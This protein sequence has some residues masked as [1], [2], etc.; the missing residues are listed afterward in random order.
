VCGFYGDGQ[1]VQAN[2]F[3]RSP[4]SQRQ[5]KRGKNETKKRNQTR[6]IVFSGEQ[7]KSFIDSGI[8]WLSMIYSLFYGGLCFM[9]LGFP[10]LFF[11]A[12]I[13]L[14]GAISYFLIERGKCKQ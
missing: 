5:N 12:N 14:I 13:Y 11:G 8:V 2:E 4:S 7:M 3:N 1:R 9:I 10:G 6:E